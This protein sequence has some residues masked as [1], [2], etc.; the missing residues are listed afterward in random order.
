M[1]KVAAI[2]SDNMV[3]Q[4]NKPIAVF[5]DGDNGRR[6]IVKLAYLEGDESI[7]IEVE[8]TV[9]DGKWL[10]YLPP[11][12]EHNACGMIV[13]D[14]EESKEFANVA[15]GEVWLCGGQSNM[16]FE[17]QN[18]IGGKEHLENDKP[19]VRFYYTQKKSY[20]DDDFYKTEEATAWTEFD[21]ET[22]KNWSAVGYLYGKRL[23]EALGVTVGLV[24]CNWGGTSA[25][26]WMSEEYLAMDEDTN[27]YLTDYAKAIAGKSE[28]QMIKE[29]KDYLVHEAQWNKKC[30]EL[31]ATVP[32][33]TW[34]EV[35]ER[36]GICQWPGPMGCINPF[37]PCGLYKTMIK[38]ITPYTMQG[39]IYYQGESDDHK[40]SYYY[41]LLSKLIQQWRDDWKDAD[42]PFLLVQ[43]PGHM[44]ENLEDQKHW[45]IIREA[46]E[47][48]SETVANTGM[49]VIIDAGEFNDIH[50]R[51][52]EP[53]GERLYRQAMYRVYDRMTEAKANSPIY[54]SHT[55]SGDKLTVSFKYVESGLE[56]IGDDEEIIGFELAGEDNIYYPA[57]ACLEDKKVVVCADEVQKPVAVRY[58]W[59]N[60]PL[61]G[62]NLYSKAGLPVAPF[63]SDKDEK[64]VVLHDTHIKQIMEL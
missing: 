3:L 6:I 51:D 45:C 34:D 42:M 53:V 14:G 55:V 29:Y 26:A 48:V 8:T 31:Y 17:L 25:S 54:D 46:Q 39:F 16:E 49:A 47:K 20:F 60:Y 19:D 52:K 35:Q 10:V 40:P 12:K 32:G 22:A 21:S 13:W 62:V 30:D 24:G 5:G 18:I 4:R 23:S 11:M 43:L 36:I 64:G 2:F 50:P 28:E 63:R 44:Y 7:N 37:R 61:K 56:V 59:T 9:V 15:I 58:L 1:L 38:R 41:K 33:I 27:T 57:K